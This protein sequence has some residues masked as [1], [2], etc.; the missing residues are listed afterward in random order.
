MY[1]I[2]LPLSSTP[3]KL[4][5]NF[6]PHL[7]ASFFDLFECSVF[8]YTLPSSFLS[9]LSLSLYYCTCTCLF[10]LHLSHLRSCMSL[11]YVYNSSR[12]SSFLHLHVYCCPHDSLSFSPCV[13]PSFPTFSILLY[14]Y[15]Y[16]VL[17]IDYCIL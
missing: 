17:V 12:F 11:S 14:T 8:S 15:K 1:A 7:C 13:S 3:L 9:F 5:S 10:F 6:I 16:A 4:I 2:P